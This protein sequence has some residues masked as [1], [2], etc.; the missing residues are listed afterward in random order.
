MELAFVESSSG[1]NDLEG[2]ARLHHVDDGPV[3]HFFGLRVKAKV[4]VEIRP[5][6]HCE[7]FARLRPHQND[8]GFLRRIF[9]RRGVDLVLNNV[10]QTKVDSQMNLIAVARRA[11][12][13]A[14]RHDF[15]SGAILFDEEKTILPVKVFLH[16][17]FNSLDTTMVEVSESNDMGK[18]RAVWVNA[19]GVVL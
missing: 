6:G 4:Q 2:R 8:R 13:T 10:L 9:L 1:R 7:N 17:S 5:I 16:R 12:L 14:I 19:S 18:H 11:Y 3:F 15:L